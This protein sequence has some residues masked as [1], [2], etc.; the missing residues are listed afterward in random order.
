MST[1]WFLILVLFRLVRKK[2][3]EIYIF[4]DSFLIFSRNIYF[5]QFTIKIWKFCQALIYYVFNLLVLG[6]ECRS[7]VWNTP[8]G[9]TS[10]ILNWK[11]TKPIISSSDQ[12]FFI[13]GQIYQNY[14]SDRFPM[15]Q[16]R[17][18]PTPWRLL[19]I[20]IQSSP[21][22]RVNADHSAATIARS[23]REHRPMAEGRDD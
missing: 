17:A 15:A 14:S 18:K 16:T 12:Y 21:V 3:M 2:I 11:S 22:I 1:W 19:T 20:A 4:R 8:F 9:S 6:I 10:Q 7:T 13:G 23:D 5:C